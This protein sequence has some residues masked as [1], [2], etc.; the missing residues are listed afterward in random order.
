MLTESTLAAAKVQAST[1][2]RDLASKTPEEQM[3][4]LTAAVDDEVSTPSSTKLELKK[5]TIG[6]NGRLL[7]DA[8]AAFPDPSSG[9]DELTSRLDIVVR[10]ALSPLD[11]AM[12]L[13]ANAVMNDPQQDNRATVVVKPNGCGIMVSNAELKASFNKDT[14]GV[15]LTIFGRPIPD[16]WI[17]VVS[18][19]LAFPLGY[20]HRI[21]SV[22]SWESQDRMEICGELYFNGD[23]PVQKKNNAW[24]FLGGSNGGNPSLPPPRRPAL[25]GGK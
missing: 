1:P 10:L 5:V 3:R 14:L 6:D 18:G 8:V 2:K 12:I 11:E 7:L 16:I 13:E 15:P 22:K 9:D 24:P 20:R 19:G 23:A 25:P 21:Q 17:P 4:L